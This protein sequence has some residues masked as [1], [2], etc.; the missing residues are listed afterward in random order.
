MKKMRNMENHRILLVEDDQNFG[1]VLRSYLEMHDY[2]VTLAKDGLEGLDN[3]RKGHFDLCIFDVMM[4]KMDGFMLAKEIRT[5]D[6]EMPI[7]FLTAKALK[8]DVLE[9]FRIGADDYITKPFL[10]EELLARIQAILKRSQK[11]EIKEEE[12]EFIIGKYH[13]N[14]PLRILTFDPGGSQEAKSKLSP[15]EAQLLR[16]FAVHM[17]DILPRS[18]ALTKIWSEDNYFTARSMDVFVTKLRKYLSLD[19]NIEI[20]NIHGNGFQLLVKAGGE[21]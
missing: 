7:I 14:F 4:P 11:T 15:K 13:F 3:Y 9:G 18:E 19:E 20:V 6:E 17:N 1:D 5:Q 8:E 10:S 12:K 21:A 2:V 16:L